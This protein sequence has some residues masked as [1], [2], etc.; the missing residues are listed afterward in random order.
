MFLIAFW[1]LETRSTFQLLS[2]KFYLLLALCLPL[3]ELVAHV[4]Y[5]NAHRTLT[6][7]FH[8]SDSIESL[9]LM[10]VNC[11]VQNDIVLRRQKI[12]SFF[13]SPF[14]SCYLVCFQVFYVV[15]HVAGIEGIASWLQSLFPERRILI[16]HGQMKDLEKRVYAFAEGRAD[17]L[18]CTTIIETGI[19]MPRVN[20]I[21]SVLPPNWEG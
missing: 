4:N 13:S 5:L 9:D 6:T 2:G 7:S 18:V 1:S 17:I 14:A 3:Q 19:D 15:Q 12:S 8:V 20:T 11:C 10:S 21:V 16:A